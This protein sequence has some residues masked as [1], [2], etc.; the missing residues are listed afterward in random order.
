MR[1]R[2]LVL[3]ALSVAL[4]TPV[5]SEVNLAATTYLAGV[6]EKGETLHFSL[7]WLGMTGGQARMRVDPRPDGHIRIESIA[8]SSSVFAKIYPVRDEIESLVTASSFSTVR[9]RKTLNERNRRKNELTVIDPARQVALRKGEEIPVPGQVFDPLST[10]YYLRTLDLT[11]GRKHYFTLLADGKVYTLQAD[12]LRREKIRTPAGSFKT[13]VVEPKMRH[14]GIFGDENNRLVIWFSD[15][16][17][18]IPVRIRSY[19]AVGNI[20]AS[21]Q[22]S[23]LGQALANNSD[24]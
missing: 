21:L 17:R 4:A 10:I 1:K 5:Y 24:F 14:G 19:L 6:F 3:A 9:F 13:V 12:V 7:S 16:E 18:R 11:P 22:S 8:V 20:T 2:H 15:D 23:A